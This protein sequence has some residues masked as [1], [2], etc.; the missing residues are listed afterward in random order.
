MM[1]GSEDDNSQADDAA[2]E[3]AAAEV[4]KTDEQSTVQQQQDEKE[5]PIDDN[6]KTQTKEAELTGET[7]ITDSNQE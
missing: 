4:A 7:T 1:K 6:A 2:A 3:S 5:V